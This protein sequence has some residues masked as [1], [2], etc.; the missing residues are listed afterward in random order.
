[1]RTS[2]IAALGLALSVLTAGT[3]VASNNGPFQD[4]GGIVAVEFESETPVLDWV[5]YST[6]DGYSG[7][8]YF[9]WDGP[10]HF[11]Q[12]GN[13][14]I[15]YDF[16]VESGGTWQLAIHN[17]HNN[18]QPDQENDVWVR[19]DNG[20]WDK[21]YSNLGTSTTFTWN[22]H[23]R[24][25]NSPQTHTDALYNLSAGQHTIYFSGRSAG[26]M[27]DRFHLHVPGHPDENNINLPE[28]PCG[29]GNGGPTVY[30]QAK[31]SSLGCLANMST[32]NPNLQ[33]ISNANNYSVVLEDAQPQKPGVFFTT[34]M[35][36]NDLP[37][38][39]GTLCLLSPLKRS[40]IVFSGGTVGVCNGSF[41]RVINDGQA[42]QTGAGFDAGPGGTSYV[43]AW[44]RDPDLNDGFN[45]ALSNAI[46]FDWQ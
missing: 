39:G 43:Q 14:V 31:P 45:V 36:P 38:N 27:M 10:N 2:Q 34:T 33:P 18:S 20:G 35:G 25:D 22:W 1:M 46:Q 5:Q 32:S 16:E 19:M 11:N 28:S 29:T 4:Q 40:S 26:W 9:R 42:I 7:S 17:R 24:F 3:A 23:T 12:P 8:G 44:H 15:R 21:V 30:C 6:Y 41:S 37:F 13:G